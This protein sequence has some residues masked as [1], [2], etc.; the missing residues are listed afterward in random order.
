MSGCSL[1][2]NCGAESVIPGHFPVENQANPFAS[3]FGFYRHAR[4]G[5]KKCSSLPGES[6]SA[7]IKKWASI[8]KLLPGFTSVVVA[9]PIAEINP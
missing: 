9:R 7:R 5:L 3:C 8:R 6:A 4:G 1:P 2:R